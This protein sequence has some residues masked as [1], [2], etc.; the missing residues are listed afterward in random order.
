MLHECWPS[1]AVVVEGIGLHVEDILV[2]LVLSIII[3]PGHLGFWPMRKTN[4]VICSRNIRQI[5]CLKHSNRIKPGF[6]VLFKFAI[7]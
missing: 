4:T 3:Y 2:S 7:I 6:G 5:F 1:P